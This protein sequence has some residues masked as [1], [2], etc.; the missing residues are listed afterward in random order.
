M[1]PSEMTADERAKV[2]AA[3]EARRS[4]P[5]RRLGDGR[6]V[7]VGPDRVAERVASGLYELVEPDVNP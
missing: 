3:I 1:D 2:L 7:H 4:V 5:M 6:I